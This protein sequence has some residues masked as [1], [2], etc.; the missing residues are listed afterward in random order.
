MSAHDKIVAVIVAT[1]TI[2]IA[3][4]LPRAENPCADPID[5]GGC[6]GPISVVL[7]RDTPWSIRE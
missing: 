1:V 7:G 6:L 5:L 2:Y 3:M 4:V